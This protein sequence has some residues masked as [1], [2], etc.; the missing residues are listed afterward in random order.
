LA[1]IELTGQELL[2]RDQKNKQVHLSLTNGDL[3]NG[4]NLAE[5]IYQED[6]KN[7]D[8]NNII[9]D[10][11]LLSKINRLINLPSISLKK[12][13][14]IR[15]YETNADSIFEQ[16]IKLEI[17]HLAEDVGALD[18]A[19][20][21]RLECYQLES[22]KQPSSYRFYFEG[23][24]GSLYI[25]TNQTEK[26]L[27][28][29]KQQYKT[30]NELSNAE[31]QTQ[32]QNNIGFY[33]QKLGKLDSAK[34]TYQNVIKNHPDTNNYSYHNTCGNLAFIYRELDSL[35]KAIK[36]LKIDYNH[37]IKHNKTAVIG[38]GLA[39]I[40]LLDKVNAHSEIDNIYAQIDSQEFKS[41]INA[42]LEYEISRGQYQINALSKNQFKKIDSLKK[43][44]NEILNDE[45][46]TKEKILSAF[47]ES[48]NELLIDQTK[49][50]IEI[51]QNLIT[52]GQKKF[53]LT[54]AIGAIICLL[55]LI[56]TL[57]WFGQRR[58]LKTNRQ[59]AEKEKEILQHQMKIN[60]NQMV[61]LALDISIRKEL[62]TKVSNKIKVIDLDEKESGRKQIQ[63]I[64]SE[65][66]EFENA[67]QSFELIKEN[68]ELLSENFYAKLSHAHPDLTNYEKELCTLIKM[69]VG[70]KEI[71]NLKNIA[72]GSVATS[73]NRLKKKLNIS[74]DISAYLNSL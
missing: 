63:E 9:Q 66:K 11:F 60:E 27:P 69:G 14:K 32:A 16:R 12:I 52:I 15:E 65:L 28:F 45:A 67:T 44:R 34:I 38:T 53:R 58:N 25:R 70:N 48:Q 22:K 74:Q 2:T 37:L 8:S 39:L 50:N 71:S 31:L 4:Y 5:E 47:F 1:P 7:N 56:T 18:L 26:C 17:C 61:D 41:P 72:P 43:L 51:K 35:E 59:L 68:T 6:L 62:S 13:F 46:S 23:A 3:I 36:Y 64:L 57:L 30:A 55:L 73:K 49:K 19:L 24:I 42:I 54:L 33:Y 20:K 40:K 10:L 21:Y 29:F